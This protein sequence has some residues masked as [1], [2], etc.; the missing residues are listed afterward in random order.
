MAARCLKVRD[1]RLS[2]ISHSVANWLV[3]LLSLAP[4]FPKRPNGPI[5]RVTLH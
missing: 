3:D 4:F 2:S 1:M 5:S